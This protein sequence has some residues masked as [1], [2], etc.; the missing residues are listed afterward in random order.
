MY[1]CGFHH[2]A[3]QPAQTCIQQ[4]CVDTGC[5][6]EDLPEVIDDREG[7]WGRVRDICAD[8]ATW[9][10]WWNVNDIF[11]RELI[12][13]IFLWRFCLLSIKNLHQ[14]CYYK[15]YLLLWK[16]NLHNIYQLYLLYHIYELNVILQKFS[17]EF[18]REIFYVSIFK[19]Y[20]F[21]FFFWFGMFI[22]FLS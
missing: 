9:W 19:R 16:T 7:W 6:P 13:Q 21:T 17:E 2:M 10:W 20:M 11:T 12:C 3:E 15:W 8:G 22:L 18:F 1:S 5:G 4:L 14:I